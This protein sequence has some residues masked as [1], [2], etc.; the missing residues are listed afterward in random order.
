MASERQ[1]PP[2]FRATSADRAEFHCSTCLACHAP[3]FVPHPSVRY[4]ADACCCAGTCAAFGRIHAI[5]P[6]KAGNT[7]CP[8][9]ICVHRRLAPEGRFC[10]RHRQQI[11]RAMATGSGWAYWRDHWPEAIVRP[12]LGQRVIRRIYGPPS[13]PCA[14]PA[15]RG[16]PRRR[17]AEALQS[18]IDPGQAGIADE[19]CTP[20]AD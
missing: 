1:S 7:A 3:P 20:T 13:R 11:Q 4:S 12:G 17:S 5:H 8:G 16:R 15:Q 2:W 14:L 9:R 10:C 6:F 19:R 18:G